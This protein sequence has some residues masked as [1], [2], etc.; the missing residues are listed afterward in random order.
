MNEDPN[1]PPTLGGHESDSGHDAN[2]FQPSAVEPTLQADGEFNLPPYDAAY[3]GSSITFLLAM[4]VLCYPI[5][6]FV[7]VFFGSLFAFIRVPLLRGSVRKRA[8]MNQQRGIVASV[9]SPL[10]MFFMS[11]LILSGATVASGIAFVAICLPTS[12]IGFT[13]NAGGGSYDNGTV[14]LAFGLG[15]TGAILCFLLIFLASLRLS[16]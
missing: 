8:I 10:R 16:V 5:P 15:I 7:P 1:E 11:A 6:F 13:Y 4:L 9:S 14:A 12:L 3:W 2:P